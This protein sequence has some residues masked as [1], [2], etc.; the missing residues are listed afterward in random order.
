MRKILVAAVAA[1]AILIGTHG[2]GVAATAE[3][4]AVI[5]RQSSPPSTFIG[6]PISSDPDLSNQDEN[7]GSD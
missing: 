2:A 1:T 7:G 4:T 3:G 6:N 5:V